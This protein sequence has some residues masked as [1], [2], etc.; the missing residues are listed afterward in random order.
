[1]IARLPQGSAP[2]PRR[3]E[4]NVGIVKKDAEWVLKQCKDLKVA[5]VR[6]WFTD[7]LGFL[8]SFDITLDELEGALSEGMGFD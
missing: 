8:K 4:Y 1:M 5:F 6:L 2:T 7:V 3:K